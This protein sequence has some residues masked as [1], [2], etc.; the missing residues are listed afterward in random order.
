MN[1]VHTLSQILIETLKEFHISKQQL[2]VD[3]LSKALI[4]K[5]ELS[6]ILYN[7]D[8]GT[9]LNANPIPTNCSNQD[10]ALSEKCYLHVTQVRSRF[11]EILATCSALLNN[12]E[13]TKKYYTIRQSI[14]DSSS[15]D[16]LMS[17][18]TDILNLLNT[19]IEDT[20]HKINYTDDFLAE[21]SKDLTQMEKQILS[22][23]TYNKEMH[24]INNEFSDGLLLHT[25]EMNQIFSTNKGMGEVRRFI[26]SKLSIIAESIER[27]RHEDGLKLQ[28][29]E[30]K[31]N[32]LQNC[33]RTNCDEILQVRDRANALEKEVLLDQLMGISNR[34]AYELQ[35]RESFRRYHRNQESFSLIFMDVDDFKTVNDTHGHQAGDRCL[36]EI[37]K[38]T[39]FCLRKT[40]FLARYGGDEIIAIL[41]GAVAADARK[42][43]EKI[44]K[45]IE[46]TVF[47]HNQEHFS[48][49]IS[50]GV[51]AVTAS[52]EGP[53]AL[54]SRVDGAIYEAKNCGRNRI[55]VL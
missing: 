39:S 20:V 54:F 7:H 36:R 25:K 31:I 53:D 4:D 15:L 55:R 18:G 26:L 49:T 42:I 24:S 13:D 21:L 35:I 9:P 11:L 10:N 12:D 28:A 32:E 46:N 51:A 30:E 14:T 6:A 37:A 41:P 50:V 1:N 2:T 23:H 27:K 45:C 33:L 52:D 34:R 43:A 17:H 29:A 44:R 47:W 5:E 22:Y 8:S 38:A 19:L 40:D 16:I 48:V 3:S